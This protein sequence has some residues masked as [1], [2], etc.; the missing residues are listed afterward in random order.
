M[1]AVVEQGKYTKAQLLAMSG[2]MLSGN[3]DFLANLYINRSPEDPEGNELKVGTLTFK[4]KDPDIGLV[5]AKKPKKGDPESPVLFRPYYK[6]YRYNVYDSKE[7]KVTA[8]TIIFT[9]FNQEII[10]DNG[11]LK[12]GHVKRGEEHT[13]KLPATSR[14]SCKIYVFGTV[15]FKG[16]TAAGN[17]IDIVDYP[18]FFKVGGINF[19]DYDKFFKD[20]NKSNRLMFQYDL[21][22][23]PVH[24]KDAMYNL[25]LS[26][27]DL[28]NQHPLTEEALA[29]LENFANY[30]VLENKRIE[31]KWKRL[32]EKEAKPGENED[33]VVSDAASDEKPLIDDFQ[34]D[35]T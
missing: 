3:K 22:L 28:T 30:V 13:S 11:L 29:T 20:F 27:A 2:Q 7:D 15:S 31:N 25:E 14:A 26:W 33:P 10:A 21:K 5:Q 8:R 1:N 35:P 12:A 17:E 18:A 23:V 6:G 24:I 9:E 19:L 34:D 16:V 4:H 32:I